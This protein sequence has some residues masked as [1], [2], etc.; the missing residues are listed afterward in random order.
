VP[1]E[2]VE[3][4]RLF[5]TRLKRF[6]VTVALTERQIIDVD[7]VDEEGA[8]QEALSHASGKGMSGF[9]A[10]PRARTPNTIERFN[11]SWS[12]EKVEP[13]SDR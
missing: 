5:M 9:R 11:G 2:S 12:V 13:V 8:R 6:H 7:A 4:W 1:I 10:E 3:P